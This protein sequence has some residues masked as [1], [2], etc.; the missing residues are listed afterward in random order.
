MFYQFIID[1]KV[2]FLPIIRIRA[3]RNYF[4]DFPQLKVGSFENDITDAFNNFGEHKL[5]SMFNYLIADLLYYKKPLKDIAPKYS[6]LISLLRK[7]QNVSIITLN[8]DLL[9]E[10]ILKRENIKYSDGFSQKQEVIFSATNE[11]I[12]LNTYQKNFNEKVQL[13][14]L[15]GSIDLYRLGINSDVQLL[16][17]VSEDYIYYKTYEVEER[18]MPIAKNIITGEII[19]RN[20]WDI[21]PQFITGTEKESIIENDKMYSELFSLF[22]EKLLESVILIIIGYSY[23]DVHINQIIQEIIPTQKLEKIININPGAKLPYRKES[24]EVINIKDL[25]ELKI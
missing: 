25:S 21:E 23:G 24:I 1:N 19:Q 5:L 14:K 17:N 20:H 13:L 10:D 18:L 3:I 15:H 11:A 6:E 4:N 7:F 22:E 2:T 9:L 16:L 12:P 8:H